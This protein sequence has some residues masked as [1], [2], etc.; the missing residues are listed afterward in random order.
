MLT[1]SATTA[2]S[3]VDEVTTVM[4]GVACMQTLSGVILGQYRAF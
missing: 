1:G 2:A 3:D 4:L